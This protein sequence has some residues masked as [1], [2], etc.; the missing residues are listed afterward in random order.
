MK[1]S[2]GK[3]PGSGTVS[4]ARRARFKEA[5]M[6]RE[7]QH[8]EK[9]D[10]H[11]KKV[12]WEQDKK[13]GNKKPHRMSALEIK[14][15]LASK[16]EKAE[17]KEKVEEERHAVFDKKTAKQEDVKEAAVDKTAAKEEPSCERRAEKCLDKRQIHGNRLQ[18]IF[19]Q[20]NEI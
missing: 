13:H 1:N 17:L 16:E 8:M 6:K 5:G 19:Y 12:D 3:K 7:N 18:V 14:Y 10:E 2:K 9:E 11:S 4:H 15:N 20:K